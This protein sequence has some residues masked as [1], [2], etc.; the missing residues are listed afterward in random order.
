MVLF[1]VEGVEGV[2]RRSLALDFLFIIICVLLSWE[3]SY[4]SLF[5]IFLFSSSRLFFFSLLF[6]IQ[7]M[8]SHLSTSFAA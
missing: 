8:W 2:K 7:R 4:H 5:T 3:R 1:Q 6:V